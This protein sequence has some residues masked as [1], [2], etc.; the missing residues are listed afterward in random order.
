M[1][2]K[3]GDKVLDLEI[4]SCQSLSTIQAAEE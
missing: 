2:A 3:Y 1:M 4:T